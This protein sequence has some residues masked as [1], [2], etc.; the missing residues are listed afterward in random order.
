MASEYQ[1]VEYAPQHRRALIGL[2]ERLQPR[3]AGVNERYFAWKLE[4]NPYIDEPMAVIAL[5]DGE[6][7]GCRSAYG[8]RWTMGDVSDVFPHADGLY[9]DP[10]HRQRGLF[11]PIDRALRRAARDRGHGSMISMSGGPVTQDLQRA[12][13]WSSVGTIS[14]RFRINSDRIGRYASLRRPTI[15]GAGRA[16]RD[17]LRRVW[18]RLPRP[19]SDDQ[20]RAVLDTIPA[21]P[22][23]V[24][25]DDVVDDDLVR[26]LAP[27]HDMQGWVP[28]RSLEFWRWRL[29]NPDRTYRVAR[30]D[31]GDDRA[32]LVMAFMPVKHNHIKVVG[33]GATSPSVMDRLLEVV[34]ASPVIHLEI[35]D[36]S[37]GGSEHA[38]ALA[39]SGLAA[40]PDQTISV[41]REGF[42]VS[43]TRGRSVGDTPWF[44]E[45]ADTMLA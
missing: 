33:A 35:A 15:G 20:V 11:V 31:D 21:I 12:T 27:R 8:T 10:A 5:V 39:P 3:A 40:D 42:V 16:M 14:R 22:P 23:A 26:L 44:I 18:S 7:V 36:T 19:A 28:D 32:C 43:T 30:W 41:R 1:I 13:G 38:D 25:I 17:G 24:S 2:I 45:L 9:I 6:P 4:E 29:G 37:L 34:L